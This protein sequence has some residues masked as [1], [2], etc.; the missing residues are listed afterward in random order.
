MQLIISLP[1]AMGA[2]SV[3]IEGLAIKWNPEV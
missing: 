2:A 1:I 3:F